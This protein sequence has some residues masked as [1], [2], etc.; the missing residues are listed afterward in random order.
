MRYLLF[1]SHGT[2]ASGMTQALG[3]LVGERE[4]VRQVAFQD[5]MALPAFKEEV[6]K[7]L[8]PMT[9][10]DEIIVLA[11]LVSGSP[12][13]T[14]M[15]AISEKLG[16]AN[17]RAIGGMNLPMAVTAVEEE[18]SPLDDTVSAMMTCAAD[19]VKQFSTDADSEDEI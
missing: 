13:T 11:D 5:G 9:A 4:D 18:D 1:V 12:L 7:V 2:L 15:A 14:T 10:E 3:M 16:L 8:A 19:Q 6:E 17:V